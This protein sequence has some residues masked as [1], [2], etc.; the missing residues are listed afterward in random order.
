[1]RLTTNR[2]LQAFG[3]ETTAGAELSRSG[4]R[5]TPHPKLSDNKYKWVIS[6]DV[7][8]ILN[9]NAQRMF[10]ELRKVCFAQ[11]FNKKIGD[12]TAAQRKK[13]L[14]AVPWVVQGSLISFLIPLA[15]RDPQADFERKENGTLYVKDEPDG[16][17]CGAKGCRAVMSLKRLISYCNRHNLAKDVTSNSTILAL[18]AVVLDYIIETETISKPAIG[19]GKA[20][21]KKSVHVPEDMT[22]P[23]QYNAEAATCVPSGG[24]FPALNGST[25]R[26]MDQH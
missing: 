21:T 5:L 18:N 17:R 23:A 3:A 14:A 20:E 10:H 6:T 11:E 16:P 15:E 12:I 25:L 1:M 24:K 13:V 22:F 9:P 7:E 8:L 19:R 4:V 26:S 2:E